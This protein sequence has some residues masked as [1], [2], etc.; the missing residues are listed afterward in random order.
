MRQAAVECFGRVLAIFSDI[1]KYRMNSMNYYR[2]GSMGS[3]GQQSKRITLLV[4]YQASQLLL[5]G[6]ELLTLSMGSMESFAKAIFSRNVF[7]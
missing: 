4:A 5:N 6:I 3:F 1:S 7:R 2:S